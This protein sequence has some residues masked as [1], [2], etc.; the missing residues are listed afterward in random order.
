MLITS[1]PAGL[2]C[3]AGNFHIDPWE[4]VERALV[5]HAHSDHAR[6]GSAGYL[7]AAPGEAVIQ[8]WVM[9]RDGSNMTRLDPSA[10]EAL[11]ALGCVTCPYPA[12]DPN[13]FPANP[14][15]AIWI[16]A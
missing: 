4:P 12:T 7:C 9:D 16:P 11:A 6:P 8:L 1:T 15:F 3:E 10:A 13:V 14:S 5:T 2:F